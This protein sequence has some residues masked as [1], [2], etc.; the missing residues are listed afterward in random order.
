MPKSSL[1]RQLNRLQ[2][3][4]SSTQTA[5]T[6]QAEEQDVEKYGK[7]VIFYLR[8]DVIVGIV[9]WNVFAKMSTARKIIRERKGSEE[10]SELAKLFDIQKEIT[11]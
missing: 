10:V 9:L 8:D 4:S 11:S 2:E 6:S 1:Q 3:N 5:S 7:G